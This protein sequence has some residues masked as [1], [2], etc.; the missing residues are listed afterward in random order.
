MRKALCAFGAAALLAVVAASPAGAAPLTVTVASK[1]REY[2]AGNPTL[3]GSVDG[4]KNGDDVS[5]NYSTAATLTSPVGDYEI[6]ASPTSNPAAKIG[7]Y[8]RIRW[9]DLQAWYEAQLP[10]ARRGS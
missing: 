5:P 2:G 3:T 7:K 1:P 4:V 8:W 9:Q 10:A 6:D